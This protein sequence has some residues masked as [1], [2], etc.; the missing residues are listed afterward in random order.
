MKQLKV[1]VRTVETTTYRVEV[2]DDFNED[3][4]TAMD[5]E[6]APVTDSDIRDWEIVDV[7]RVG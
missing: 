3:D 1:T 2:D 6:D 7:E 5:I 4:L